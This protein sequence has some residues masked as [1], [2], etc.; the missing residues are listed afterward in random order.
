MGIKIDI[1][2]RLKRL[3]PYL[4]VEID[5]AKRKKA[6][7]GKDIIDLGIGDPDTPTPGYIIDALNEAVKDPSTHKYA[8]DSGMMEFRETIA[9][10]Y[11][12]RFGVSLD[13]VTEVLPLIGSKEGIAHIPLAF[14]NPGD[15]AF[16]PNP[17]YPAYR[18]GVILAGGDPCD[19]PLKEER[20]FLP[21]LDSISRG[22][23]SK[24]K[25]LFLNY[26]NNPTGAVCGKDF[27]KKAVDFGIKNNI[28]V[29]S[30]AAY[31]ELSYDGYSPCSILEADRAKEAA[32]EFHS[33]SKTFNMT[34]WRVGMVCGN[35]DVIAALA[36]VKSNV[37]SGIFNAIQ[38]AGIAALKGGDN[39]LDAM[40]DMY[41]RRRDTL[42]DGLR[43]IGWEI[44]KPK[45]AFYI[46]AKVIKGRDSK[47]LCKTILNNADVVVTP[48][49]GFGSY[50]EG[51]VRMALTVSQ[52]R[53]KE[54]VD[55]I[56]KVI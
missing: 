33:L 2:D 48:G 8:L 15:T 24:A 40:R 21:D 11:K 49:V 22:A 12:K 25:L 30:D 6:A 16:V 4:F 42:V 34:G 19:M 41:Q 44:Q 1:T 37:D 32:V 35:K 5:R 36:K 45:A 18:S 27:Y 9:G 53:L 39:V 23:A 31:T 17:G 55:R 3:P 54:A 56:K 29:A 43:S 38:R 7:E 50:G 46:W 26:P 14:I 47:Q 28:V 10:W 20:G 51:Y 52:D 13:P